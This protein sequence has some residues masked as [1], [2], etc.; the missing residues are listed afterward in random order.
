[1]YATPRFF[2]DMT[3]LLVLLKIEKP[4]APLKAQQGGEL[5]P[6]PPREQPGNLNETSISQVV[7]R[8]WN[9]GYPQVGPW[10]EA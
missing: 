10:A 9:T 4:R 6:G 1:M 7:N 5:K 3:L 8:L 2:S